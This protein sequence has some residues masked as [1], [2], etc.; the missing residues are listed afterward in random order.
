MVSPLATADRHRRLALIAALLAR[1]DGGARA[2]AVRAWRSLSLTEAE[3]ARFWPAH[4]AALADHHGGRMQ[5]LLGRR[6]ADQA[7]RML[8]LVSANTRAVAEARIALA[9]R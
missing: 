4:G 5:M 6:A 9:G 2:E 8:R 7:R 1:G 3:Q